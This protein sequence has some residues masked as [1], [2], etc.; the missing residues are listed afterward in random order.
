M[1][2]QVERRRILYPV[3]LSL[4]AA[5]AAATPVPSQA[6][7]GQ[8]HGGSGGRYFEYT[9][10]AGW[11]LVGLRGS[12]GILLDNIQAICGRV[13]PGNQIQESSPQGPVFGGNRP[14]DKGVTCPAAYAITLALI[15]ENDSNPHVGAI[16]LSCTELVNRQYGGV[17]GID[18][19]GSGN[20]EG[21]ESTTFF[22]PGD[23]GG[24]GDV[25]ACN[26][27]YAVGIRGR[28][29]NY[30]D[31]FGL[32]CGQ[33]VAVAEP[34]AP[35]TLNKRKKA[36]ILA[37]DPNAFS[38]SSSIPQT[39]KTLNKRK[40]PDSWG[41]PPAEQ[42]GGAG[43]ASLNS[44]G[45]VSPY[46]KGPGWT[47]SAPAT[48]PPT[49]PPPDAPQAPIPA[50]EI[51]GSYSTTVEVNDSRCMFKDMRGSGERMLQLAP[52]QGIVIPLNEYDNFFGGPVTLNLNGLQLSQSTTIPLVF[53]P[54]SAQVP[55]SFDGAF[56]QDG[57]QFNVKFE[58][59]NALCRIA[60]TIRGQRQN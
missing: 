12:A 8:I 5:A 16:R 39:Q 22:S 45:S 30:L 41:T 2:G 49:A 43:G 51:G 6:Q 13:G 31:A 48:S 24:R 25:S 19:R 40:R 32:V 35:K 15:S 60:G 9:C 18:I 26:G 7:Q 10:P 11:V 42:T 21:Y 34:T 38:S 37:R 33:A 52:N 47:G 4:L 36:T 59:G 20:L 1:S 44:D 14:M 17:V 57:G 46:S 56:S 27:Q 29:Q 55:A 50:A 54:A 23:E 58:A 53:G 28:A 3:R